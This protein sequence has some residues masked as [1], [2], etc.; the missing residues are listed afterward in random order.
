MSIYYLLL[1]S[2]NS[3]V[4]MRYC[5]LRIFR[6][7]C[8]GNLPRKPLA[9]VTVVILL[10]I[11]RPDYPVKIDVLCLKEDRKRMCGFMPRTTIT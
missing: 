1:G 8:L 2:F 3:L 10:K 6:R 4:K 11:V 5:Y 9:G 7:L